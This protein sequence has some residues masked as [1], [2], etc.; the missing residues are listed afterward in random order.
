MNNQQY[1]IRAVKFNDV[2]TGIQ[3]QHIFTLSLQG[4]AFHNCQVG[5][6][7]TAAPKSSVGSL[8][9]M[10]SEATATDQLIVS[11]H[12][13]SA[14]GS[15][16]IENVRINNVGKAVSDRNGTVIL[17]GSRRA[18]TVKSFI[19]GTVYRNA[20]TGAYMETSGSYSRS[21]ALLD[22]SGAYWTK[23]RPQYEQYS[24]SCFSSVKDFGAR[25]DGK[26][27][28]TRAINA[29]LKANVNRRITYF[30]AGNYRVSDTILA[31]AGSRLVG[32]AWST[33]SGTFF[34]QAHLRCCHRCN[35]HVL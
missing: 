33:L 34:F 16:I 18:A 27:D 26:A 14:D 12:T 11:Q 20:T 6:N 30:P 25:G 13:K 31:P 15:I 1:A 21:R 10:D 28:D 9:L 17:A 32:E 23:S 3:V 5:V 24:S 29:A 22:N 2:A 19:Q 4:L 8:I 7:F 35:T